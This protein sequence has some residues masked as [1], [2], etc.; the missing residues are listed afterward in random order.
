MAPQCLDTDACL[1]LPYL[2]SGV[3][4]AGDDPVPV[5]VHLDTPDSVRV[6][7]HGHPAGDAG[8]VDG[9]GEVPHLDC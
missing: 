1:Q 8:P 5:P 3:I 2:E 4:R 6:A 9:D 7:H